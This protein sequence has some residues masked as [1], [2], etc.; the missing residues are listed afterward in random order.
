M[1]PAA[2]L[3]AASHPSPVADELVRERF[4]EV[5]GI[6]GA[7]AA[8]SVEYQ[9]G[10]TEQAEDG[11]ALTDLTFSNRLGEDVPCVLMRPPTGAADVPDVSADTSGATTNPAPAI[12]CMPGTSGDAQQLAQPQLH[13]QFQH[14]GPLLGWARELARRGFIALAVTVRGTEARSTAEAKERE[15][16][17]L[18]PWGRTLIGEGVREALQAVRLLQSLPDVDGDRV[19]ATGFS[20]GGQMS[21][22]AAAV[23]PWLAAAA[24]VA[25][26]IGSVAAF[27]RQGDLDRHGAP[28]YLPNLLRYFDHPQLARVCLCP[29]PLLIVAPMEDEDMPAAGVDTLLAELEPAYQAAGA[30]AKLEVRRPERNHLYEVAYFEW[31]AAFFD[32]VLR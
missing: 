28:W 8:G 31:V 23:A 13:R 2:R 18:L 29:R 21:W 24:P 6:D 11:V 27:I 15:A 3:V 32:R 30:A 20:L 17:C 16:K 1:N 7:P 4:L 12:V 19:A 14:R 25:G 26:G 5:L 9:L 22:Q 10:A